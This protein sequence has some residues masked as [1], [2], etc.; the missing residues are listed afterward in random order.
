MQIKGKTWKNRFL[1]LSKR[2]RTLVL[3]VLDITVI[4]LILFFA[5]VKVERRTSDQY[6]TQYYEQFEANLDTF[7]S[8]RDSTDNCS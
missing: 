3:V 7:S 6:R 8:I 1:A 2:Q 5:L 4:W